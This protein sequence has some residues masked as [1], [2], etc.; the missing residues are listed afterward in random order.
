MRKKV[1]EWKGPVT[2]QNTTSQQMFLSVTSFSGRR[3]EFLENVL[4]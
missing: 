1:R 3:E 2:A 4:Y